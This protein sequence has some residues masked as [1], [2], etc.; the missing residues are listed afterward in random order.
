MCA[1]HNAL[2]TRL[3]SGGKFRF[4]S[5]MSSALMHHLCR[6]GRPAFS[7]LPVLC[8]F[9]LI[10][11]QRE[12][13]CFSAGKDGYF[14]SEGFSRQLPLATAAHT[15]PTG[16][17]GALVVFCF[18]TRISKPH[19]ALHRLSF[20]FASKTRLP[21]PLKGEGRGITFLGLVRSALS[22]QN[23]VTLAQQG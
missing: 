16:P 1:A 6:P 3:M 15:A 18:P 12:A 10:F 19:I 17:S 11:S 13:R 8:P 5:R 9:C 21:L 4:T 20:V 2:Q 22:V 7:F 14:V 23:W